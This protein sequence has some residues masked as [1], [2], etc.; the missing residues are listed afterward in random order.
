[1]LGGLCVLVL[2]GSAAVPNQAVTPGMADELGMLHRD[3]GELIAV[4]R[5]RPI[6]GPGAAPTAG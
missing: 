1:M 2:G 3:F 6:A 4:M 5:E